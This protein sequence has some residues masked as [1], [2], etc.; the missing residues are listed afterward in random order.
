MAHFLPR[1]ANASYSPCILYKGT[2][3]RNTLKFQDHR[4]GLRALPRKAMECGFS[5]STP[6]HDLVIGLFVNRYEFGLSV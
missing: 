4:E 5:C 1:T 6:R 2:S 3:G